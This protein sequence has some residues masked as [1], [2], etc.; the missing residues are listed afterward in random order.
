MASRPLARPMA[1]RKAPRKAPRSTRPAKRPAR[2]PGGKKA[3]RPA[4]KAA[5]R[6]APARKTARKAA[7]KPARKPARQPAKTPKRARTTVRKASS[8]KAAR[9]GPAKAAARPTAARSKAS[10]ARP[11]ARP[12]ARP[13][14]PA[15]PR[16][17]P[18]PAPAREEVEFREVAKPLRIAL[19]GA[20]GRI[21][22]RIAQEALARGHHVTAAMRHPEKLELRHPN[23][24]AVRADASDPLM[25]R[26][27]AKGH[28]VVAAAVA[29]PMQSPEELADAAVALAQGTREANVPR[30]V[31]VG[32]AG[33][34]QVGGG[35]QLM[36]SPQFPADWRPT[37]L[38]HRDAMQ[39][40]AERSGGLEWTCI[41]PPAFIEPGKRTGKYRAGTEQLLTDA[42]GESR[43]SME[44]FAVAFLDEVE[45]PKNVGRRMTVAY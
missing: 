41:S 9:P 37:A 3:A 11:V 14:A 35:R 12:A 28:D 33:S 34:L 43:I 23:L 22:S 26:A 19:F 7:R 8:R 16:P 18:A 40:L 36:D 4:R 44:D 1:A 2:A 24:R 6:K 10:T 38:A 25:V 21:G 5:A 31:W 29:P 45:R 42:K 27:V 15:K 17:A 32:G 13:A 20:S 30:L 39:K